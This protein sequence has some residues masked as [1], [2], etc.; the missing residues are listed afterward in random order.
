M[1][2]SHSHSEEIEPLSEKE[3][4]A[5]MAGAALISFRIGMKVFSLQ[6]LR[7]KERDGDCGY[8]FG[9]FAQPVGKNDR[10]IFDIGNPKARELDIN[11][12]AALRPFYTV[13]DYHSR[14]LDFCSVA[15]KSA[16]DSARSAEGKT[17][18][19]YVYCWAAEQIDRHKAL[20]ETIAKRLMEKKSL[21]ASDLEGLV[22]HLGTIVL[23][24]SA[25]SETLH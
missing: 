14:H 5:R 22:G 18:N 12:V 2:A 23:A 3:A 6:W 8:G 13:E 15:D 9:H 25:G 16:V 11:V 4:A 21:N 10:L 1:S 19:D 24:E 7:I 20:I 17:S